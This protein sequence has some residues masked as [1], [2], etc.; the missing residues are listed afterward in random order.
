[1]YFS[2]GQKILSS[3]EL[4]Y[5]VEGDGGTRDGWIAARVHSSH[6]FVPIP[7]ISYSPCFLSFANLQT[8]LPEE[9][10]WA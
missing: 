4:T 2:S 1:V 3:S 9:S 8:R 6:V 7:G 5:S 10:I